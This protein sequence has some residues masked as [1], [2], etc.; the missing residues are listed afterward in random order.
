MWSAPWYV[1]DGGG[2]VGV[3]CMQFL[4][5]GEGNMYHFV[6]ERICSMPL[7]SHLNVSHQDTV[8]TPHACSPTNNPTNNPTNKPQTSEL[9]GNVIDLCPVGALTNK[10]AA[11]TY[12]SWELKPTESIDVSDALGSNIRVDSRGMEVMRILPINNDAV[13]EEWLSDKARFQFDGLKRQ[14]LVVPMVKKAG[15]EGGQVCDG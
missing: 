7:S 5:G 14:R 4:A 8:F 2:W 6:L 15:Q 3:G 12:R 9:S 1:V 10:P 13:N 11:F